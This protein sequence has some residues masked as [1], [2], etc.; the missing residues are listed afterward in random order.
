MNNLISNNGTTVEANNGPKA[1]SKKH[2]CRHSCGCR[3]LPTGIKHLSSGSNNNANH[4]ALIPPKS[5][6]HRN[7]D[8]KCLIYTFN[9]SQWNLISGRHGRITNIPSN[10]SN[11]TVLFAAHD[12]Q[13]E[14][15][16]LN[17]LNES[18]VELDSNA[19]MN[20]GS[21]VITSNLHGHFNLKSLVNNHPH[22][23]SKFE[24]KD[25]YKLP[26]VNSEFYRGL[27]SEIDKTFRK[28]LRIILKPVKKSV[29][30]N[31]QKN[32]TTIRARL[33]MKVAK[34]LW[35]INDKKATC[36]M[37]GKIAT[38]LDQL[39]NFD[40]DHVHR[41]NKTDSITTMISN[42][43]PG[44]MVAELDKCQILCRAPCHYNKT[45]SEV[46]S[47]QEGD[48]FESDKSTFESSLLFNN[49]DPDESED[50]NSVDSGRQPLI[51]NLINSKENSNINHH[52][53]NNSNNTQTV[54]ESDS[55][56]IN[57]NNNKRKAL[58]S[59]IN[60]NNYTSDS[61]TPKRTL[62]PARKRPTT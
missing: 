15:N 19:N 59:A 21:L 62:G 56:N 28:I 40:C 6:A 51:T 7:H 61:I 11:N 25:W 29:R 24:S 58:N 33:F 44:L 30:N 16:N 14:T 1:T 53:V 60:Y 54:L 41:H 10:S 57:T 5:N 9:L 39:K 3:G 35:M 20:T 48:E 47:G 38:T 2:G 52:S 22:I 45:S 8:E 27:V 17:M 18:G 36:H 12:Q 46:Q 49:N 4:E 26:P 42:R 34:Y 23:Y 55:I 31:N 37:C 32:I 43:K 50:A 13:A